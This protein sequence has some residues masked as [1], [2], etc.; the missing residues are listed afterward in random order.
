MAIKYLLLSDPLQK[1]FATLALGKA[2]NCVVQNVQLLL[3]LYTFNL[4]V[5]DSGVLKSPTIIVDLS[6]SFC[7]S[8]RFYFMFLTQRKAL[9][10]QD[11]HTLHPAGPQPHS[12]T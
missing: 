5:P 2:F 10:V 4:L 12:C 11:L 7:S 8:I 6:I 9:E 3:I 1:K